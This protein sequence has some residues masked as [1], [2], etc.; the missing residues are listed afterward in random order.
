MRPGKDKRR[1][2]SN[3]IAPVFPGWSTMHDVHGFMNGRIRHHVC[4]LTQLFILHALFF[5]QLL[6]FLASF[7]AALGLPAQYV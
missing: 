6:Q 7:N 4:I 1:Q 3:F 2:K 5:R